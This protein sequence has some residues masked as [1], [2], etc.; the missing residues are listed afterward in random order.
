MGLFNRKKREI[1]FVKPKNNCADKLSTLNV[2][3][4]DFDFSTMEEIEVSLSEE[5]EGVVKAYDI[6]YEDAEGDFDSL[7]ITEKENGKRE[8]FAIQVNRGEKSLRDLVDKY[9]DTLGDPQGVYSK[10]HK[11]DLM[12]MQDY[13]AMEMRDWRF[14]DYT[15]C[16]GYNLR[17]AEV[18][19]VRITEL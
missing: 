3:P 11:T 10:F 15:I 2:L 9:C 18:Y 17:D 13:D 4:K 14:S 6:N 16:I 12:M 1:P 7:S 8:L 19:F 5:L